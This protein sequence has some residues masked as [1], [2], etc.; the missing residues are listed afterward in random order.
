MEADIHAQPHSTFASSP[1]RVGVFL[2]TEGSFRSWRLLWERR[3]MRVGAADAHF[4]RFPQRFWR[5]APREP[6][7]RTRNRRS[8]S[9]RNVMKSQALSLQET[10]RH[11][12][13]LSRTR[14]LNIA[15]LAAHFAKLWS[16]VAT[17]PPLWE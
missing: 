1:E 14:I 12:Q 15:R 2:V 10:G 5:L 8:K 11:P 13:I 9:R 7:V 16:A 4:P 17:E 6:N 3:K